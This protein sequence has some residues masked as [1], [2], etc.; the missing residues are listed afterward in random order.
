MIFFFNMALNLKCYII[1]D[2]VMV[3]SVIVL[4]P[5]PASA[6]AV[7]FCAVVLKGNVEGTAFRMCVCVC[8]CLCVII[9]MYTSLHVL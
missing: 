2:H 7:A 5:L 1:H 9:Y 8:N 4:I 6:G 3:W